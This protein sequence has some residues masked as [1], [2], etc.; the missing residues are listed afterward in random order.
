MAYSG[1]VL[2]WRTRKPPVP[3]NERWSGYVVHERRP[4][5]SLNTSDGV[6]VGLEDLPLLETTG[7][8]V[9]NRVLGR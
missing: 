1:G 7:G 5:L 3:R 4:L 8:G 2:R 6:V 9:C